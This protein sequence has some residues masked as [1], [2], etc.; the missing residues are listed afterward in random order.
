MQGVGGE[1]MS[2]AWVTEPEEVLQ[3]QEPVFELWAACHPNC[4]SYVFAMPR[5]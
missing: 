5:C 4:S 1:V 3:N 2:L